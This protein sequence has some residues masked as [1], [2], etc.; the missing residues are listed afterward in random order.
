MMTGIGNM[1]IQEVNIKHADINAEVTKLGKYFGS[2]SVEDTV[3]VCLRYIESKRDKVDSGVHSLPCTDIVA[4][5]RSIATSIENGEFPKCD[6]LTW[7]YGTKVG[8]LGTSSSSVA[9]REAVF[10]LNVGLS[11]IMAAIT[12]GMM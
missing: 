4:G 10:D 1:S 9:A 8:Q 7:V 6:S 2:M 5:L 12:S 11:V 3:G